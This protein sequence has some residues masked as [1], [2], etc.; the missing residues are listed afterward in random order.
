M[1]RAGA[2][3]SGLGSA[4]VA[5]PAILI[6]DDD[7]A[8][9]CYLSDVCRE[10]GLVAVHVGS[11]AGVPALLA[12]H[13]F[14]SLLVQLWMPGTD[15]LEFIRGVRERWPRVAIVAM[16]PFASLEAAQRALAAGASEYVTKAID[17]EDML[18]RIDR[19]IG[20]SRSA[21]KSG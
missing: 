4:G 13:E 5:A 20:Q 10:A 21:G 15:A 11:L 17:P 3:P 8:F 6:V 2:K 7:E 19:A 12:E 1:G 14:A 18:R 16:T 9:R